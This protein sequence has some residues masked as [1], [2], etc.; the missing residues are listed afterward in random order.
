MIGVELLK[1]FYLLRGEMGDDL[2][3]PTPLRT[4][5]ETVADQRSFKAGDVIFGEG[6]V[7]DAMYVVAHGEVDIVKADSAVIATRSPGEEFG[8][9]RDCLLIHVGYDSL[10]AVL[11]KNPQAAALFYRNGA[12]FLT[13]RLRQT[14]LDLQFERDRNRSHL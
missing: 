8:E 3:S 12:A 10:R 4:L 9:R 13:E 2:T 7:A 11:R 5:I 1:E 14:S 6:D